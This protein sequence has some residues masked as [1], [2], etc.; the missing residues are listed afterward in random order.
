ML[1]PSGI[2]AE[3]RSRSPAI[4]RSATLGPGCLSP[5]NT[6]SL[7]GLDCGKCMENRTHQS[8]AQSRRSRCSSSIVRNMPREKDRGV[9][10]VSL[11]RMFAHE[12]EPSS[13][14][15]QPWFSGF[16]LQRQADDRSGRRSGIGQ[17]RPLDDAAVVL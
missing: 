5:G 1:D 9:Y 2:R 15:H 4:N 12:V 13:A 16:Y 7:P 10:C 17:C 6:E 11:W 14:P 3:W 8:I